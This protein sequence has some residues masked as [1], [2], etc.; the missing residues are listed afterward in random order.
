MTLPNI[1]G[2]EGVK[3]AIFDLTIPDV[4]ERR[5][6]RWIAE[7]KAMAVRALGLA[8]INKLESIIRNREQAT[9]KGKPVAVRYENPKF[10][11]P[12]TTTSKT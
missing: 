1:A 7:S 12:C 6:R 8:S 11:Q 5:E 10:N 9:L 3:I 4:N 2:E